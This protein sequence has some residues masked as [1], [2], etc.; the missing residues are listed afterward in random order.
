MVL[1]SL[2]S[3]FFQV[4]EPYFTASACGNGQVCNLAVPVS[5]GPTQL[6]ARAMEATSWSITCAAREGVVARKSL[7]LQ[8]VSGELHFLLF[9]EASWS[10]AEEGCMLKL[11]GQAGAEL[12][13]P[14]AGEQHTM[15]F[16]DKQLGYTPRALYNLYLQD[17]GRPLPE[18]KLLPEPCR[19]PVY[20]HALPLCWLG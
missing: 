3:P 20:V 1:A 17:F 9:F 2:L 10:G 8:S 6:G 13:V 15:A 11:L 19:C 16:C 12:Q 5:M 18:A 14:R 7:Q 4:Q